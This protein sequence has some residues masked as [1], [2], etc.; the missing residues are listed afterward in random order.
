MLRMIGVS[1]SFGSVRANRDIE[2]TVPA[3][4]IV[5]LL[6]ETSFLLRLQL[7]GDP[8]RP[9]LAG[10]R[11]PQFEEAVDAGVEWAVG[12]EAKADRQQAGSQ[13]VNPLLTDSLLL[14]N[15]LR[16]RRLVGNSIY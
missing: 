11:I 16:H 5:G 7:R 3:Q 14:G 10:L 15:L 12:M 4:R 8:L 6:G 1:K 9:D 2:L 13:E